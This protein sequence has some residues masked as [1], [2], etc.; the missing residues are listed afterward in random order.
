MYI[1]SMNRSR[2]R[3]DVYYLNQIWRIPLE[4]EGPNPGIDK[5]TI[6]YKEN[7]DTTKHCEVLRD[8]RYVHYIGTR[9]PRFDRF[10]AENLDSISPLANPY[11]KQTEIFDSRNWRFLIKQ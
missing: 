8:E 6:V 1:I 10:E 7:N 9:Y 5:Y 3:K 11:R 4:S 2:N